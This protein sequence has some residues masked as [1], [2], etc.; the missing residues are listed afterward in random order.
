MVSAHLYAPY[1]FALN[2]AG[3]SQWSSAVDE[4]TREIRDAF[5]RL[6][7]LF[8]S[9]GIPVVLTEFG[10]VDKHNEAAR[11]AWASYVTDQAFAAHIPCVWWD[12]SLWSPDDRAWRYPDLLTALTRRGM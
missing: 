2:E 4:D 5:D 6:T 12:T 3:T 7:R 9:R 1:D 8:T 10:A 11:T